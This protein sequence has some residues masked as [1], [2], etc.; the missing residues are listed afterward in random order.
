M[1]A[2]HL[3]RAVLASGFFATSVIGGAA[4]VFILYTIGTATRLCVE[5][6]FARTLGPLGFGAYSYL[7][8]WATIL[9]LVGGLGLGQSLL[10]FVPE[11]RVTGDHARLQGLIRFSRYGSLAG[12]LVTGSCAAV[13]LMALHPPAIRPGEILISMAIVPIVALL[14]TQTEL[15]RS[16]ER[17]VV[18]YLPFAPGR[19][20]LTGITGVLIFALRGP[21]PEGALLAALVGAT[22]AVIVQWMYFRPQ[23]VERTESPR[24]QYEMSLWVRVAGPL[25]LV[26]AFGA[27]IDQAGV[28]VVGMAIGAG[29]SGLFAAA[30]R[31]AL[32]ASF[33]LI[34]INA[35]AAPVISRL[36]VTRQQD[37]LRHFTQNAARASALL[38]LVGGG[39]LFVWAVPALELFGSGFSQGAVT[40]RILLVGQL[41]HSSTGPVGILLSTTGHQD[42]VAIA[43]G[44]AAIA[45]V[46]AAAFVARP[47]GIEGVAI[48]LV[49]AKVAW[50]GWLV[51]TARRRMGIRS[52]V[53]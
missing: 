10:R 41:I 18:A 33:A 53:M 20:A 37:S 39:V 50:N 8:S 13:G 27:V 6:F 51:W 26:G 7:F 42:D 2:R 16:Y 23:G 15:A 35:V 25:L 47:F 11:Y 9:A 52:F 21:L 28:I 22:G 4:W 5:L 40:L 32:V 19:F 49:A 34:A 48:A 14:S 1:R 46:A 17:I 31:L 44:A 24:S 12:G 43:Q 29:P 36:H 30:S 45:F 3:T 38:S